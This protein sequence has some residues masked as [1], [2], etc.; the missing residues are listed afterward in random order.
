MPNDKPSRNPSEEVIAT[1]YAVLPELSIVKLCAGSRLFAFGP[2][3][4]D[5]PPL[6]S[7]KEGMRCRLRVGPSLNKVLGVQ[8]LC[9]LADARTM[10]R[11][12]RGCGAPVLYLDYD[13]VLHHENVLRH[14]RRGIYAG[15][16]GFT[17]FEHAPLLELLLQ[18]FPA[19]SIVLSTSWVRVLGYSRALERLPKG[20]QARVIGSTF[21]SEMDEEI[22]VSKRRGQQVLEDVTRRKPS[23]WI[24]LDDTD[25]GCGLLPVPLTPT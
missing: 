8:L 13:G 18:P 22:F 12:P 3:V 21:H 11:R 23:S 10:P 1:V 7:F 5:A 9:D 2:H 19:V 25:E 24:A 20:L 15:E 6:S 14:P 16:P 4:P 17:L